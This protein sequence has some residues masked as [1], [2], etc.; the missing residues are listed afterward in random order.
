MHFNT[1]GGSALLGRREIPA[2]L[3]IREVEAV[4]DDD[5]GLELLRKANEPF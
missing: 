5:L 4:V 1:S 2:V 3:P